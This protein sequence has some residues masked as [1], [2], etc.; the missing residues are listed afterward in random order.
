VRVLPHERRSDSLERLDASLFAALGLVAV[1]ARLDAW[2]RTYGR[3]RAGAPA[4]AATSAEDEGILLALVGLV[5]LRRT[6]GAHLVALTADG[7]ARRMSAVPAP[8]ETLPAHGPD[9]TRGLLR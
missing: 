5:A 9:G 2:L 3:R 4:P 7:H 1:C 6:C 8:T